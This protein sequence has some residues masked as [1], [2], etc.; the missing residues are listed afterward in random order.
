[1]H[2]TM[3][4][5]SL[6]CGLL[7][8]LGWVSHSWPSWRST[9][10]TDRKTCWTAWSMRRSSCWAIPYAAALTYWIK[11][12]PWFDSLWKHSTWS[13]FLNGMIWDETKSWHALTWIVFQGSFCHR[14]VW[15]TL[16]LHLTQLLDSLAVICGRPVKLYK[17]LTRMCIKGCL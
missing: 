16:L 9:I 10:T 14:N 6:D 8:W 11:K 4:P 12:V 2:A 7:G 15:C 1:M 5:F 3:S 13:N 17:T